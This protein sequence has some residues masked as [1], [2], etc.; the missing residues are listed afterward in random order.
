[1]ATLEQLMREVESLPEEER[2]R[3]MEAISKDYEGNEANMSEQSNTASALRGTPMQGMRD[4]GRFKV[5]ANPLEMLGSSMQRGAGM[6]M[7]QDIANKRD[8]N[9]ALSQAAIEKVLLGIGGGAGRGGVQPGTQ[10]N[11]ARAM[12]EWQGQ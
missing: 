11:I 3:F 10:E 8:A 12:R 2:A 1:M 5:A 9:S 4:A 6:K 7:Q